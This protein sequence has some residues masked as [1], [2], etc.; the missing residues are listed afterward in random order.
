MPL[1]H[2]VLASTAARL[3]VHLTALSTC[4]VSMFTHS[5]SLPVLFPAEQP[6]PNGGSRSGPRP[7]DGSVWTGHQSLINL[8]E[9]IF[10]E[11]FPSRH[12]Y[13]QQVEPV[14]PV[15]CHSSTQSSQTN[16]LFTL[17][18][19]RPMEEPQLA[20]AVSIPNPECSVS[21]GGPNIFRRL[22]TNSM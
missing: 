13:R 11:R 15:T 6:S 4:P 14:S 1:I 10:M 16:C 20:A 5:T 2:P 9:Q 18:Q 12:S 19:Q 21:A 7:S 8:A 22:N 17:H 3:S